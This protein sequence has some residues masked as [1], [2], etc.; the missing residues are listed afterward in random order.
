MAGA[1][2]AVSRVGLGWRLTF[3]L[4]VMRSG[5]RADVSRQTL[6]RT[7]SG[8]A[9][10]HSRPNTLVRERCLDRCVTMVT[11]GGEKMAKPV[12]VQLSEKERHLLGV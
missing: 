9:A 2:E 6:R 4:L 5:T 12:L 11:C 7:Y 3:V 10:Q 1:A 8:L